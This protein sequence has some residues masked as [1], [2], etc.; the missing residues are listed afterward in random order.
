MRSCLSRL[1]AI[2]VALTLGLAGCDSS[3]SDGAALADSGGATDGAAAGAVS[4]SAASDA[5]PDGAPGDAPPHA[6]LDVDVALL[7]AEQLVF[8]VSAPSGSGV[9]EQ[10]LL[11]RHGAS[12]VY[13]YGDGR[14]LVPGLLPEASG[15]RPYTTFT[16][17]TAELQSL[18]DL[19]DPAWAAAS[20]AAY[21]ACE[22]PGGVPTT[23][24]VELPGLVFEASANP[25]F[26]S[27]EPIPPLCGDTWDEGPPPAGLVHLVAELHALT[28]RATEP[29]TPA[30][31]VLLGCAPGG[32]V[33]ECAH[34]MEAAWPLDL[35]ALTAACPS[36][37]ELPTVAVPP[38]DDAAVQAALG[39][40][41]RRYGGS[42]TLVGG[43]CVQLGC[44]AVLP[45]E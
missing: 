9:V 38:A 33:P 35:S 20:A 34:A 25:G 31:H 23:V 5:A 45:H 11:S 2:A 4:D 41:P 29:W 8:S 3:G 22:L 7:P 27:P 42:M 39:G 6:T 18:V 36:D 15:C 40:L 19:V 30:A 28:D 21:V 24:A 32:T 10:A 16:L 26:G 43:A 37:G 44:D 17:T 1:P 12:A 14:V 13:V